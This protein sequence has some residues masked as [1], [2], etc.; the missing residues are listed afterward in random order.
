MCAWGI[1][2]HAPEG[3]ETHGIRTSA[4]GCVRRH[5]FTSRQPF[6]SVLDGVFADISQPD[7][8]Q[9]FGKLAACTSHEEFTSLTRQAQGSVGLMRFLQLDLD[10]VLTLDNHGDRQAGAAQRPV[11]ECRRDGRADQADE[12]QRRAGWV[13]PPDR[14]AD[15][16]VVWVGTREAGPVPPG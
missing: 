2:D 5:V 13:Q 10:Q 6:A 4:S 9:L 1:P 7:I 8:S 11:P 12:Q 15:L 14:M 16:G 3:K